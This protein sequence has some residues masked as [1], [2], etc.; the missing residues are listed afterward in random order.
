[1]KLNTARDGEEFRN[2]DVC[3]GRSYV[4]SDQVDVAKISIRGEYP[5]RAW[6][7]NEEAHEMAVI[8][9][10]T[11]W[12]E[13]RGE[14]RRELAEGDVVYLSP[15]ERFR[16]GGEFDMIVSCGPAFD[17]AKYHTEAV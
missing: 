5:A 13:V 4:A 6:A 11:G 10:G 2:S 12:L 9:S 17:P 15:L 8:I 3:Y 14:Q 7:Y 16:W 1:M